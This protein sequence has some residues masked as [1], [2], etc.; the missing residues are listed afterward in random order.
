[1]R[2]AATSPARD[3]A[4]AVFDDD[5]AATS[6]ARDDE[7]PVRQPALDDDDAVPVFDGDDV[8]PS[9][10]DDSSSEESMTTAW[11]TELSRRSWQHRLETPWSVVPLPKAFVGNA[12]PDDVGVV[13]QFT[14]T[15]QQH[16]EELLQRMLAARPAT[17][18][19]TATSPRAATSPRTATS[20][21]AATSPRTAT[22][23]LAKALA[24]AEHPATSQPENK[25]AEH[26]FGVRM[27]MWSDWQ[28]LYEHELNLMKQS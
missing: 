26:D 10:F 1:M 5:D 8:V 2:P 17:S 21:R 3:D 14:P 22:C 27:F 23:T 11:I 20:P 12:P 9:P 7:V 18:P 15:N 24:V 6:P 13:E 25:K 19:R 28:K 16:L 4:V